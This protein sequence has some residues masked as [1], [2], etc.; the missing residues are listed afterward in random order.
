MSSK[1]GGV[2][3]E[4]GVVGGYEVIL[5][6]ATSPITLTNQSARNL[7]IQ[8]PNGPKLI[9]LP[10]TGVKAGEVFRLQVEGA[11]ETNLVTIRTASLSNIDFIGGEGFIEVM[12]LRDNPTLAEHWKVI[13]A[14]EETSLITVTTTQAV[15][16][17]MNFRCF[18]ERPRLINAL[19]GIHFAAS[20][21]ATAATF[22]E[23]RW[24]A[25]TIP[26]RFRPGANRNQP[27]GVLTLSANQTG[28]AIFFANGQVD[29]RKFDGS[30]FASTSGLP[31]QQIQWM[32]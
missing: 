27:C 19:C 4:G 29:F 2:K 1:F 9:T 24:P 11:T 28:H 6:T 13:D 12:A 5:G 17:T 20:S 10:S 15:A 31:S 14:Q 25:G 23:I 18:R 16:V 30:N 26:E 7:F 32:Y 8:N 22:I 21:T 3:L